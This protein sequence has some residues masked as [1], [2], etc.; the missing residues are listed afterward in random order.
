[1]AI[2]RT[3]RRDRDTDQRRSRRRGARPAPRQRGTIELPRLAVIRSVHDSEHAS[4]RE[5]AG[6]HSVDASAHTAQQE[7]GSQVRRCRHRIRAD[8]EQDLRGRR[9]AVPD[10]Y[11]TI[12]DVDVEMQERLAGILELRA[13]DPQQQMMLDS[14]LSEIEFPPGARVLEI[15]S[16][17]GAKNDHATMRNAVAR[18]RG[19]P[20]ARTARRS[21]RPRSLQRRSPGQNRRAPMRTRWPRR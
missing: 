8:H 21:Q 2:C 20:D 14:Y 5:P 3:S 19:D 13:A 4:P 12:A 11:A 1:M 9:C 18:G 10:V 16:G 6:D 17:T 15:G 7:C